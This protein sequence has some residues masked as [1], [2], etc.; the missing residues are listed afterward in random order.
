MWKNSSCTHI[1][2]AYNALFT[3]C[4]LETFYWRLLPFFSNHLCKGSI[5][6]ESVS[7]RENASE[8]AHSNNFKQL[9]WNHC[10]TSN[11][12]SSE[13]HLKWM[14]RRCGALSI[15]TLYHL[16]WSW[17][18]LYIRTFGSISNCICAS[19]YGFHSSHVYWSTIVCL[20]H[21]T[22]R[23]LPHKFIRDFNGN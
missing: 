14:Q 23:H 21:T 22:A 6:I 11:E 15:Y 18:T 1:L 20:K 12:F 9:A 16:R 4:T 7:W 19:T 10:K 8:N 17:R 3:I 5:T 13:I 2:L